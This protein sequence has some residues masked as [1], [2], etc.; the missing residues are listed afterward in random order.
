[1]TCMLAQTIALSFTLS[2]QSWPNNNV[3]K[4]VPVYALTFD[5]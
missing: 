1:M 4:G 2:R 3:M 5:S